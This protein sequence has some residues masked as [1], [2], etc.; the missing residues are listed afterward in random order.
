MIGSFKRAV[1][2]IIRRRG[3]QPLHERLLRLAKVGMNHWG[4]AVISES[5]ELETLSF[6]AQRVTSDAP[7]VFD[8]G[9]NNGAYALW[10]VDRFPSGTIVHAFEPASVAYRAL[11][12]QVDKRGLPSRILCHQIGLSD[13]VGHATLY[14]PHP[15]SSI[16]TMHPEVGKAEMPGRSKEV[17][18]LGTLDEFCREQ[19]VQKI[20]L[21]KID[22]EGHE[23]SVLRGGSQL[24]RE[25]RIGHIQF[26]FGERHIDARVFFKDI[27][28]L[29]APNYKIHRIVRNGP[30]PIQRYS[31][32]LEIF[33]TANFLAVRSDEP[34]NGSTPP[35]A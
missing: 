30:W 22:A 34:S 28:D 19:G 10:A 15:G 13:A 8:V 35:K 16:A 24:L 21:L 17:V 18:Q 14:G 25:G 11:T 7:V 26:E 6:V 29:L 9:A 4:G 12:E 27:Y 5:G 33:N 20:D 2:R 3:F 1:V 23:L 31:P 32:D